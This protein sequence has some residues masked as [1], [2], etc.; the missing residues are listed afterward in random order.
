MPLSN[1]TVFALVLL[2]V[3]APGLLPAQEPYLVD[4]FTSPLVR[5]NGLA[6]TEVLAASSGLYYSFI[7]PSTTE[8][9]SH[10]VGEPEALGNAAVFLGYVDG[11]GY[12][13]WRSDG[14]DAGT[15]LLADGIQGVLEDLLVVA[16]GKVYFV[17]DQGA[18]LWV[19]DGTAAGTHALDNPWGS[20]RVEGCSSDAQLL[21]SFAGR[22]LFTSGFSLWTTNPAGPGLFRIRQL[23]HCSPD[24]VTFQGRLFFFAEDLGGREHL[25]SS[26]GTPVGTAR[27]QDPPGRSGTRRL[28][29]PLPQIPPA[30]A[31]PG[32]PSSA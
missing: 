9:T 27:L 20:S 17:I 18:T 7:T 26:N 23:G 21:G 10:P 24:P 2:G 11:H 29:P 12:E 1:R 28:S 31:P 19:S 14:T 3:L 22:L 6:S 8:S 32:R 15:T 16:A 25:W 4:D 5:E 30:R 13:L